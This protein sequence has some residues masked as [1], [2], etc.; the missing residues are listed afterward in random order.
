MS[1]H[2]MPH[3]QLPP[4]LT[5]TL[6]VLLLASWVRSFRGLFHAL[7][8][9]GNTDTRLMINVLVAVLLSAGSATCLRFMYWNE[10]IVVQADVGGG[11]QEVKDV[12][13]AGEMR[14]NEERREAEQG[15]T[16]VGGHAVSSDRRRGEPGADRRDGAARS[17]ARRGS[18]QTLLQAQAPAQKQVSGSA[19][20]TAPAPTLPRAQKDTNS[21]NRSKQ[22]Q[23][24]PTSKN[25]PN[26]EHIYKRSPKKPASSPE[27]T[28]KSGE[29]YTSTPAAPRLFT[30]IFKLFKTSRSRSG[31]QRRSPKGTDALS[32]SSV[33]KDTSEKQ[34][35]S[36]PRLTEKETKPAD[37]PPRVV[38]PKRQVGLKGLWRSLWGQG[39]QGVDQG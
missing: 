20:T 1:T 16:A 37:L 21:S 28:A 35:S 31:D 18:L 34:R 5:H 26:Y 7:E 9:S 3:S 38:S 36:T 24:T 32:S 6:T 25:P 15:I 13:D 39:G 27:T 14:K 2:L 30:S 23:K 29:Q 8:D 17:S 11:A 4:T 12:R 33:P 19:P 22:P 10:G